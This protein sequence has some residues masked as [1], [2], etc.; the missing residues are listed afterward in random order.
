[1]IKDLFSLKGKEFY[2]GFLVLSIIIFGYIYSI[3]PTL[4]TKFQNRLISLTVESIEDL[5]ENVL[6]QILSYV[7]TEDLIQKMIK[8]PVLLEKTEKLLGI[9][10][11]KHTKYIYIV[12]KKGKIYRYLIDGSREDKAIPGE[13]FEPLNPEIWDEALETGKP[14]VIMQ[15][16]INTIG[17]TYLRPIIQNK[18]P[19]AILAIDYSAETIQEIR[20]IINTTRMLIEGILII[21]FIFLNIIIY[22]AIKN[23]YLK[24]KAYID[25]LT[26]TFNRNYLEDI[27]SLLNPGSYHIA[28]I[29]LDD[30]KKIN[31]T[32]GHDVGDRV[33]Q[34]VAEA[35]QKSVRKDE[36]IVIRY[37]GEEFLVLIKAGRKDKKRSI[38]AAERILRDIK[39]TKIKINGENISVTASIGLNISTEKS[40]SIYDA[41]K[42]SDIALYQAKAN[43]KDRIEIYSEKKEGSSPYITI[44]EIQKYLEEKRLICHYQPITNL[45]TG[46]VSHY[47]AL[48]RLIDYD[49]NI[50]YPNKFIPVIENTFL[51]SRLTKS[52]IEYNRNILKEHKN[53]KIS[54][55]LSPSDLFTEAIVDLLKEIAVK[56]KLADRLILEII[57]NENITSYEKMQNTLLDLKSY[58]YRI[59]IDDFGSGYSNFIYLITL[60]VDFLKID[61]NIIKTI[62]KDHISYVVTET[63]NNFC[64][65]VNIK[66]VAEY[67]ENEQIC[68]TVKNLDIDFGQGYYFS[69]PMSIEEVIKNIN[70]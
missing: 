64:K 3:M 66:T 70:Q 46:E 52:V 8:D 9:L 29:D 48:V 5:S 57:E 54:I 39:D 51:Y 14:K 7:G 22:G 10:I 38:N 21:S 42:K 47:E 41:I 19:K 69:K 37:G 63:I 12:F 50:L 24:K 28:L 32:Y 34:K 55:N 65:K 43:G 11:T 53:L 4:E 45:K 25:N 16:S 60:E 58:G 40:Y 1:M 59:G 62:D 30:F 17:F 20:E 61:A 2:I 27:V 67:I 15:N 56:D 31:D 44:G 23:I 33:L 13:V 49:G 26:K 36:D 35:I 68:K 6:D 18:T